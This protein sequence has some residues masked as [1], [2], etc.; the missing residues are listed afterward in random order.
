MRKIMNFILV[1]AILAV[2]YLFAKPHIPRWTVMAVL[3]HLENDQFEEIFLQTDLSPNEEALLRQAL[4]TADFEVGTSQ[5]IGNQAHVTVEATLLDISQL[6]LENRQQLLANALGN[7]GSIL[8]GLFAGDAADIAIGELLVLL[9]DESISVPFKTRE[10]VVVLDRQILWFVPNF[11][12]TQDNFQ[13]ML[14]QEIH[15]DF[16]ELLQ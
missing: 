9:E 10:V 13:D 4:M 1:A 6:V 11:E 14:A 5:I 7:I 16:M 12:A 15:L 2:A 3:N 8:S